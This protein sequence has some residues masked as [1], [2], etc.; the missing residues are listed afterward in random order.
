MQNIDI[1]YGNYE[2]T[3]SVERTDWGGFIH[4]PNNLQHHIFSLRWLRDYPT[5]LRAR[6]A[7][8]FCTYFQENSSAKCKFYLGKYADHCASIRMRVLSQISLSSKDSNIREVV[9]KE[10]LNTFNSIYIGETYNFG[11]NHAVMCDLALLD[12]SEIFEATSD[13]IRIIKERLIDNIKCIFNTETGAC[14]EHSI[15]YQEFNLNLIHDVYLTLLKLPRECISLTELEI[16]NKQLGKI[17][18]FSRILLYGSYIKDYGY[19]PIGDS[20]EACKPK[21]LDKV[22][23]VGAPCGLLPGAPNPLIFFS[24]SYGVYLYKSREILFT[25]QNAFHSIVHK[26]DDD[27][28]IT[29]AIFGEP[30]FIDG[31]HHDFLTKTLGLKQTKCHSMPVCEEHN[32][33]LSSELTKSSLIKVAHMG[34]DISAT[35]S[36]YVDFGVSRRVKLSKNIIFLT[37][38]I[39]PSGRKLVTQFILSPFLK[40]RR[41]SNSITE[42]YSERSRITL[43]HHS[44]LILDS[45]NCVF[46]GEAVTAERI[47]FGHAS[48]TKCEV[49]LP[50]LLEFDFSQPNSLVTDEDLLKH[51]EHDTETTT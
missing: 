47:R 51:S 6:L 4:L 39:Y 40:V 15:S 9:R 38:S 49:H 24:K 27:L 20:F 35:H 30:F 13:M 2:I 28:S 37:D 1:Q 36:R 23:G 22:F 25:L 45:V 46:K 12:C 41:T 14:K 17:K 44:K 50:N 21:I 31:G 33:S 8:S 11:G 42:I 32:L 18:Q 16:L 26:Q 29:L 5:E 7:N 19:I 3:I 34:A 43:I 10:F 48:V